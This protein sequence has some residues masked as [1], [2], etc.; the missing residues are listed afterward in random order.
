MINVAVLGYGV[1]GSGV[2]EIIRKNS[3]SISKKAG[4]QITVKRIL[5]IRDFPD[6]P[7]KDILTKNADDIFNDPDINVVVE[8]IGGITAAYE[9]TKRALTQGKH[10]VT[11]NKEL[12]ATHGPELL[13]LARENRVNYLF[14]ASVGGGI[15]IIRPL[16]RCLAANEIRSIVGILN[17]TTNYILTQMKKEGKE[18]D[19]ALKEAQKNGYAE[20]DPTADIEGH[21]ACR[22]IAILSSIA[23]DEFV[24]YKKIY[25]EGITKITPS[26]I[27]Y[28]EKMNSTIKL[29]AMSEKLNGMIETRVS[30]VI[31]ENTHPLAGVED[32]FNAILVNG[33]AIGEA[34]FYGRGAGKLPTAS[35]VVADVIEIVKHWGSFGGYNWNVKEENNVIDIMETESKFFVR[36]KVN[37]KDK[38]TNEIEKLY[39]K[40]EWLKPLEAANG[41]ELVFI[42]E[43]ILEKDAK[44]MLKKVSQ[45][46]CVEEV[47]STIR[48]F[49][50]RP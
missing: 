16:N 12:V 17:G 1:V 3:L 27:M 38:G 29:I 11:S 15:P 37:D 31:I 43:C 19:V 48:V 22:K 7:D 33:D 34:M 49:D 28:A 9:F 32:V 20:A 18:F 39:Q 8:T 46:D 50:Y 24:D 47:L 40:V 13:K 35:A 26:D 30:P 45:L 10:V 4:K 2:V 14:E 6:S 25:T 36:V 41:E 44:D 21:D 5:D 42:T 23:Y